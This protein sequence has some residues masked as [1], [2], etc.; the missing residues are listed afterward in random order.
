[1]V[2][3]KPLGFE[4]YKLQKLKIM[5]A[6]YLFFGTPDLHSH[7]RY[8]CIKKYFQCAKTI[9]VG[10]GIGLISLAFRRL[11]N[12]PLVILTYTEE[13]ERLARELIKGGAALKS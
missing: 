7:I 5:K 4:L 3:M 9:D 10:A 12:K 6:Y 2:I 11:C 13:E 8:R 1:M